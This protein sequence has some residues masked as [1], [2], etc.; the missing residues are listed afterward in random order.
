VPHL[1]QFGTVLPPIHMYGISLSLVPH[2]AQFGTVLPRRDRDGRWRKPIGATFGTI[3]YSVAT[4]RIILLL[5][6]PSAGKSFCWQM[7]NRCH[8][9][10]NSVQCC[11]LVCTR[12]ARQTLRKC[13][14]WHN[15]VQCC[16]PSF[17]KSFHNRILHLFCE[18]VKAN[19]VMIVDQ[20]L[21]LVLTTGLQTSYGLR[22]VLFAKINT[23]PDLATTYIKFITFTKSST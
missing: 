6:N 21:Q 22:A 7:A 18:R 5:A 1:A 3:R 12:P 16:H 23:T 2:L 9:W 4:R 17:P 19:N 10:H 20:L 13:H 8:I 14:I 11:H 15:S